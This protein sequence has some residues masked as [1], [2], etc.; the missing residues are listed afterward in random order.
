MSPEAF[1]PLPDIEDKILPTSEWVKSAFLDPESTDV[2]NPDL[3]TSTE[4]IDLTQ[5]L[6]ESLEMFSEIA[7]GDEIEGFDVFSVFINSS[8]SGV[9]EQFLDEDIQMTLYDAIL[10]TWKFPVNSFEFW[11]A[12]VS[13]TFQENSQE[14]QS[15]VADI[16]SQEAEVTYE[17]NM[18]EATIR[19]RGK[20]IMDIHSNLD[21][22]SLSSD[23]DEYHE[24]LILEGNWTD[25]QREKVKLIQAQIIYEIDNNRALETQILPQARAQ[26]P[27]IYS[28][29]RQSLITLDPNFEARI[30]AFELPD[31]WVETLPAEEQ[32]RTSSALWQRID[33]IDDNAKQT[34]NIF[35]LEMDSG[36]V[37]EYDVV[38][39]ERTLSRDGYRLSSQVEDTWDYQTPKL[40][41][42]RVEQ[43]HLPKINIINAAISAIEEKQ[44]DAWDL[45]EIRA[46]ILSIPGIWELGID[47]MS[48]DSWEAIKTAFRDAFSYH[49]NEIDTAREEYKDAL[50]ILRDWH[51]ASLERRDRKVQQ[52]LRFF[53]SIWFTDIPQYIT[54]QV[55]DTLNSNNS[56]RAQLWFNEVID[57][58]NGQLGI[59][60]NLWESES[61]DLQDQK[62]FAE[63][64]NMLLG[65]SDSDGNP[66][67]NVD[68][69]GTSSP[70]S[71]SDS[72]QWEARFMML[73]NES[74]ILIWWAGK[75][76][77][78]LQDSL[79]K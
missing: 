45:A 1:G 11:Q 4:I 69:I 58:E 78:N 5:E 42:M 61:I 47:F 73:L 6:G 68:A 9:Q 32:I 19:E 3:D 76:I 31:I 59:D 46:T 7:E 26:W 50:F 65:V 60:T 54:D 33:D 29:V 16:T 39:N 62:A 70:L 24:L 12:I 56:L 57:F 2:K 77:Q 28:E 8:D 21:L 13:G 41:Y 22:S 17:A 40:D 53:E 35:S 37:V 43:E 67:I 38:T 72:Q 51:R 30:L 14:I 48:M 27:E 71:F 64:V 20:I 79:Q 10:D 66:P 23:F 75:A 15:D 36:E 44:I 55:V 74:G 52:V 49:S 63:F 25:E 18:E 34:W